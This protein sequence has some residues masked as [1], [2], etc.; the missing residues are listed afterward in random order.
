MTPSVVISYWRVD[1]SWALPRALRMVS[2]RLSR[3]FPR[4]R[5]G[6]SWVGFSWNVAITQVSPRSIP[7]KMK[8]S[9]SKVLPTPEGPASRVEAPAVVAISQHGIQRRNAGG[10]PFLRAVIAVKLDKVGHARKHVDTGRREPVGVLPRQ[11]VAAAQFDDREDPPPAFG[12]RSVQTTRRQLRSSGYAG[13]VFGS[14]LFSQPIKEIP[15]LDRP[16]KNS[17]EPSTFPPD[18]L[19]FNPRTLLPATAYTRR[20][21]QGPR[22]AA[23]HPQGLALTP[24]RTAP[25]SQS[26]KQALSLL[27]AE[28]QM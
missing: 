14:K 20:P 24:A 26:P 12:S 13:N 11:G 9:A 6:S 28:S 10:H 27:R 15:V 1:G 18:L 8:W 7:A 2:A 5:F 3:E 19:I 21:Q 23:G 25:H 22:L 16:R 4:R 17:N